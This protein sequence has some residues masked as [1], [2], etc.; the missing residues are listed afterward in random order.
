VTV[1]KNKTILVISP[2]SWGKMFVSKHH[3]AI[4]LAKRGNDVYF[5]NPP[6]Q[7][8]SE[9]KSYI[10]II[11]SGICE[12]LWLINHKLSFPYNIKFHALPV[13]HLLMKYHVKKI[14]KCIDKPVDI[15]WSFDLGNIYPLRFFGSTLYKIFHPVDEPMDRIAIDSAK[16]SDIIFSVTKEIL[17]KYT[18]FS[19]P[20]Y[21]INHGISDDFLLPVD[22]NKPPGNPVRIGFAGNLLRVD[23]DRTVTLEIII[24]NPNIIFECWGSY[25]SAQSNIGGGGDEGTTQFIAALMAQ[26]NV[27]LHGA[28]SSNELAKAIHRVDGLLICYDVKKDQSKGTNYHKVM[29]YISTGKVIVSN[30]VTTYQG[31][32]DLVRMVVSRE[33]NKE[34]PH[35]FKDTIN[36][37][38]EF[39]APAMQ[40]KRIEYAAQNTYANQLIRIEKI[41]D[42]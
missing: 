32:P 5:L 36:R 19:A 8:A 2:Q 11:E 29:E 39:N 25:A 12:N 22:I 31:Q 33:N 23:I 24:Q 16:G 14:L 37:L 18:Q 40:Q 20:K 4:E 17:D 28:V 30:N 27:I 34:L 7:E 1:L 3:Y 21:F 41:I 6:D 42:N 35:L 26:K 38:S 9:R 10:E 13:F 15:L